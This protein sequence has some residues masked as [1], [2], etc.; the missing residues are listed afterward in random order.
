MNNFLIFSLIYI[1]KHKTDRK[2]NSYEENQI[3][4]NQIQEN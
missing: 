4:K 2:E 1:T 3:Q